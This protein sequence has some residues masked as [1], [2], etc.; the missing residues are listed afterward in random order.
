MLSNETLPRCINSTP[1]PPTRC[2]NKVTEWQQGPSRAHDH[3]VQDART[4]LGGPSERALFA[5]LIQ[6]RHPPLV[7]SAPAYR[8]TMPPP[9]RPEQAACRGR[10]RGSTL[11][12]YLRRSL[13]SLSHGDERAGRGRGV[14]EAWLRLLQ[15]CCC[16][17]CARTSSP[18]Y[19]GSEHL[20]GAAFATID[21]SSAEH[22][23]D[24]MEQSTCPMGL[25]W[26]STLSLAGR[27][28]SP[29]LRV[30]IAPSPQ[31]HRAAR[32]MRATQGRT[33]PSLSIFYQRV[34]ELER[35]A[36]SR[37]AWSDRSPITDQRAGQTDARPRERNSSKNGMDSISIS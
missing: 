3:N 22:M 4:V 35:P 24:G 27:I 15:P 14:G 11:H 12:V 29:P 16:P 37:P 19:C 17:A 23:P 20:S 28:R 26:G 18:G 9:T 36:E 32:V 10:R 31:P 21:V 13:P 2:A 34:T 1:P 7:G 8:E 30:A 25:Q 6:T 5:A 33:T